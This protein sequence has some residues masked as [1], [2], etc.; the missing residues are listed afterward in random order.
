MDKEEPHAQYP[1]SIEYACRDQR[2]VIVYRVTCVREVKQSLVNARVSETGWRRRLPPW[3]DQC[4][5]A[6]RWDYLC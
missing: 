4:I 3:P 6:D 2:Q 1:I 5:R